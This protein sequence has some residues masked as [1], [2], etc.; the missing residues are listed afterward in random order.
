M[1]LSL[2]EVEVAAKRA[3]RGAHYPWGL[4][5]EAAQ[6]TRWLCENGLDGCAV[7]LSLLKMN[8][9]VENFGRVAEIDQSIWKGVTGKLCP[10][11]TGASL[12][13]CASCLRNTNI[14]MENVAEPALLIPFAASASERIGENL[15][16]SWS[17]SAAITDGTELEFTGSLDHFAM[18]V[19]IT[20]SK[21]TGRPIKRQTR[22][23]PK[24][25][26]W[27]D[28]NSFAARTYAPATDESRLRGAGSGVSDND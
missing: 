16:V 14:H 3:T 23:N 10:I 26:I 2:N 21:M 17:Q 1:N 24:F 8:D 27:K 28:L 4:A 5:E 12:S 7:L 13:D 11:A 18:R 25:R 6:A 19:A 20:K 9:S 22:A 15:M